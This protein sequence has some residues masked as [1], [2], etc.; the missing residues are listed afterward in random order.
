M[1][2]I[3]MVLLAVVVG[4]LP[5]EKRIQ[6]AENQADWNVLIDDSFEGYSMG[7]KADTV[8][9]S[10]YRPMIEPGNAG[11]LKG[12]A[13]VVELPGKSE[14]GL[15]VYDNYNSVNEAVYRN[16]TSVVRT[17]DK[18][19]GIVKAEISFMQPGPKRERTKVL[20]LLSSDGDYIARITAD[21]GQEQFVF[22]SK[23]GP[24]NMYP[25]ELNRWYDITLIVDIVNDQ[26]LVYV[27][28]NLC[29]SKA[30]TVE[31]RSDGTTTSEKIRQNIAML[32]MV[33]AGGS[34]N[35]VNAFYV[36]HI[37][38]SS[39]PPAVKALAPTDVRAYPR[40]KEIYVEWP[41]LASARSNNVYVATKPDAKDEEYVKAVSKY[42]KRNMPNDYVSI[43]KIGSDSIQNG[44][45]YYVKVTQNTR[46]LANNSDTEVESA[47]RES[48]AVAVTPVARIGLNSPASS[49]IDTV[50]VNDTKNI[51]SWSIQSNLIQGSHP[52][53]DTSNVITKL[54]E[55]YV[56]LDW[57][58][59][60]SAS[61]AYSSTEELASFVLVDDADVF[62]AV[63]RKTLAAS[64]AWFSAWKLTG[65]VIELD[66]GAE[67]LDIYQQTYAAQSEVSLGKIGQKNGTGYF[68][69]VKGRSIRLDILE[70]VVD[71]A[72]YTV[73]GTIFSNINLSIRLNGKVVME[74]APYQAHSTFA[75]DMELQPGLNEIEL[76][77]KLDSGSIWTR[78]LQ[79]QYEVISGRISFTDSKGNEL[80]G[81]VP[82]STNMVKT[83]LVNQSSSNQSFIVIFAL[84]NDK[85]SM[86]SYST[87]SVQLAAGEAKTVST[88]LQVPSVGSGYKVKAY[89]W[90]SIRGMK[91]LGSSSL[92][93]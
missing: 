89:V 64:L 61:N 92:L 29:F 76:K 24:D 11:V 17:F 40:D 91:T 53:G 85:S 54:P 87:V 65:D 93:K 70:E 77:G 78:K 45:T 10:V 72:S 8:G 74:S 47:L 46:L 14:K 4:S 16:Y 59:T 36:D 43:N 7:T 63:N 9:Y 1:F 51:A 31:V 57:V 35:P 38:V 28:G 3:W 13:T 88:G 58:Q 66:G 21:P 86:M 71:S 33:T 41:P 19:E 18:Q 49:V 80:S 62:V 12:D 55:G 37:K 73:S 90:D 25:Y 22:D 75:Q 42:N 81:L 84:Y 82:G 5:I 2:T 60:A 68:I 56:G 6:A 52:F 39:K 30:P 48:K 50:Y 44:K 27:D 23:T 67:V 20:N 15:Y 32:E 69:L 26:V 83:E 79:V 34:P